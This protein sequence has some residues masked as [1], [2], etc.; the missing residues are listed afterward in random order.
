MVPFPGGVLG[1][2]GRCRMKLSNPHVLSILVVLAVLSCS[3]CAPS[4]KA[5]SVDA[6]KLAFALMF[7]GVCAVLC[8]SIGGVSLVKASRRKKD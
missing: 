1:V 3:G 5:I 8:S 4:P 2:E 6:P 7:V